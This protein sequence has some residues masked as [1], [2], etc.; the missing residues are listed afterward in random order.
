MFPD[1]LKASARVDL[2]QLIFLIRPAIRTELYRSV[3]LDVVKRFAWSI[4][5]FAVLDHEGFLVLSRSPA[6]S[7]K[8]L[9]LDRSAGDHTFMLGRVLG[10]PLC[11]SRAAALVGEHALDIWSDRIA[12]QEFRGNFNAIDPSGYHTGN[13]LISHIPCSARCRSSLSM[14]LDLKR[15]L[16]PAESGRKSRTLRHVAVD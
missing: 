1:W 10:Y 6:L 2:A 12:A 4:G 5:Y 16:N 14:A 8:I 11:C 15:R 7:R 13:A 9:L 3:S